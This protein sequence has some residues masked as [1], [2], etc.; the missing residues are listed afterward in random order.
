MRDAIEQFRSAMSA[1]GIPPP[2]H[3]EPDGNIHRFPTNGRPNDDAGW[4]VMF[5]DGIPAG[6]F[7]DWRSN[8]GQSWRAEMARRPT[9]QEEIA[10]RARIEAIQRARREELALQHADARRRSS[11]MWSSTMEASADHP[12]LAAKR[13]QPHGVRS[14]G[15]SLVVPVFQGSELQ[16]LQFIPPDGKAKRFLRGGRA[17][18]GYFLVGEPRDILCVA[19]GFAT[20]A[21]IHEATSL[22]AVVAFNAGNL[23]PV[24]RAMKER[25]PDCRLLVCA[26]DDAG[27]PGNPGLTKAREAA[28]AVGARLAVPTFPEPRPADA[29]DFNDMARLLGAAAVRAAIENA[30]S[31]DALSDW[32]EPG[33]ITAELKPVPAFDP[34]T[35]LPEA[36]RGW[37]IDEAERM[38]C[39]P[40]YI[41]AAAVVSLG[42]IVGARCAI[43]PKAHD[44][45]MIVPN[46][47]GGIVG[48]PASKKSPAWGAALK[49]MDRL[50]NAAGEAHRAALADYDMAR[51]VHDAQK[52]ALQDQIKQAARKPGKGDPT[53]IARQLRAHSEQEPA[54]PPLRRYRTN[55][56]T[57]EKLGELLRDNPAGLLVLRDELVG[58]L[59]NWEREGREGERAFFLEAWN[60]NQSFDTDRIGRGHV[61]IPNLCVSLFGGIQPD[62]LTGYLEQAAHTFANDGMLQRFQLLVFPDP[63][64]WEWRDRAPN[65]AA[66]DAAFA[67]FDALSGFDPVDWGAAPADEVTKF[68]C[69]WFDREA[70]Q[71]FIE[72]STEWHRERLPAEDDPLMQQHL[73]KYD[74]LFPALALLFHLVECA[75]TGLRGPVSGDSA[76]RAG[77]WCEFLQAHARRCYGLLKDEGLRAAQSLAAKL[78]RGELP[79]GFTAREIRRKQWRH[80]TTEE[81][82]EAALDWLV[83][84]NWLRAEETGGTGPGGGRRTL[85]Y[86]IN[87]AL[88]KRLVAT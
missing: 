20:A 31:A 27:K 48:N 75:S 63:R 59:A 83:E 67:A 14:Y 43:R 74:K 49:P 58:L 25:F 9:P 53:E 7:G 32:P 55:D 22:P 12:Y 15:A 50:I 21:S 64:R 60:G 65:R 57:V 38:P 72:W 24:A 35:L 81:A 30:L 51:V 44:S 5:Q 46:L 68:P 18:G 33:P 47:W 39:P 28:A 17:G 86:R 40:E 88:A 54:E 78:Q 45:W 79:D 77:A 73:T 36:L 70:Q 37:I 23:L 66:R 1:A 34:E 16:T 13:V 8:E 6:A 11:A 19:E 41:A 4:Y 84:E 61:S 76:F 80:L 82:T 3:I 10:C 71:I 69:F 62:K 26:D 2:S 29:K 87:P 42:S 85:R 56:S 52:D